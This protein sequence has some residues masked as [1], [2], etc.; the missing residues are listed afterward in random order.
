[1]PDIFVGYS[2][3]ASKQTIVIETI[4]RAKKIALESDNRANR[5]RAIRIL[6]DMGL[7]ALDSLI[8]VSESGMT[9]DDRLL[10]MEGLSR[11]I[12]ALPEET[13]GE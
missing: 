10:A 11:L 2:G 13:E 1:M 3:T 8:A 5:T 9:E 12:R 4:D 7:P 6:I